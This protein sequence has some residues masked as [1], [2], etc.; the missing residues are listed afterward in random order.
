MA[1]MIVLF[2]AVV[3]VGKYFLLAVHQYLNQ[4]VFSRSLTAW[5]LSL[6]KKEKKCVL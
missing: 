3:N 2:V 4:V 1:D 6:K 5:I